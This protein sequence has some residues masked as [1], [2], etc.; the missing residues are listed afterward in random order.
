MAPGNDGFR[1]HVPDMRAPTVPQARQPEPEDAIHRVKAQA[2]TLGGALQ[3]QN[4]MAQSQD[5]SLKDG[6]GTQSTSQGEQ[7]EQEE[8]QHGINEPTGPQRY[9]QRLQSIRSFR[10]HNSSRLY[11]RHGDAR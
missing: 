8:G 2:A 5:L 3:H 1:L 11:L 10:W 7:Q 9:G 6:A 4:L